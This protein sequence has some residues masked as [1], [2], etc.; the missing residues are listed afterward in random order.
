MTNSSIEPAKAARDKLEPLGWDCKGR[1]HGEHGAVLTASRGE[2]LL[3]ITWETGMVVSQ[4]YS[5]FRDAMRNNM[6]LRIR[7]VRA[8]LDFNPETAPDDFIIQKLSGMKV[9]YWNKLAD[10]EESA[11]LAPMNKGVYSITHFYTGKG[12]EVIDSRTIQ[13]IDAHG[14]GFRAFRLGALIKVGN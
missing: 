9:T 3:C 14:G 5:L 2:E 1:A 13:F 6:P 11:V 12:A 7:A 8:R 10:T 4:D